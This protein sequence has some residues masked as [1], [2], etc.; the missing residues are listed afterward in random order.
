MFRALLALCTKL[1]LAILWVFSLVSMLNPQGKN[2]R[3][4]RQ[5]RG[6]AMI[7]LTIITPIVAQ[8][9]VE[10]KGSLFNPKQ[11]IKG[12]HGVSHIRNHL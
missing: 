5:A 7:I 6:I 11:W 12:R 4:R 2:A 1:P 9:V 8:L 3:E 10:K